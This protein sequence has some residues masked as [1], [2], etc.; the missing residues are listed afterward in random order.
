MNNNK[1]ET[2][3]LSS[4][5]MNFDPFASYTASTDKILNAKELN[6]NNYSDEE[7]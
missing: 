4:D 7:S 6:S 3:E 2:A 1:G 5:A